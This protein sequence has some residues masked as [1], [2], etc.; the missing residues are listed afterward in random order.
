MPP[1]SK[2]PADYIDPDTLF[3][4]FQ[5]KPMLDEEAAAYALEHPQ[6]D[7]YLCHGLELYATHEPC[8]MCSMAILHSRM[9]KVV[10]ARPMPLTGGMC[11][12]DRGEGNPELEKKGG[13]RGLG[14]WW[15]RELNWSLSAWQWEVAERLMPADV[16]PETHT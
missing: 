8:T 2:D 11:A 9:S 4:P 10:F 12:E 15:R 7:G 13:G 1:P 14:L 6:P 5:D 3:S 16:D